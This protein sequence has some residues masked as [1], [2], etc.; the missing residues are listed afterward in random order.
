MT[1]AR[2]SHETLSVMI[3][4]AIVEDNDALRAELRALVE[5]TTDFSLVGDYASA[6]AA[7]ACLASDRPDVMLMDVHLSGM[8]G[9]EAVRR[10][11]TEQPSVQAV[12][13]TVFE[14]ND[15]I[16]D[17]L[18]AGER[19]HVQV[20]DLGDAVTVERR[21]KTGHEDLVRP[22]ARPLAQREQRADDGQADGRRQRIAGPHRKHRRD[23][24]SQRQQHRE[25]SRHRHRMAHS[26][27]GRGLACNPAHMI[28]LPR[29][30][31]PLLVLFAV[32]AM[33]CVCTQSSG[34]I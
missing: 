12:M 28:S 9:V 13:L 25:G 21:R 2:P 10:L 6:E 31:S 1:S 29:R 4:V 15:W 34:D 24:Q 20:R 27:I 26:P 33:W 23:Q 19:P 16:F 5:G 17:A 32:V 7:L 22:H 8:N 11:K 18:R 14:H 3:R 30:T